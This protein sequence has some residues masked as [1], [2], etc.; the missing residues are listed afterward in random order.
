VRIPE[1]AYR[2]DSETAIC[3]GSRCGAPLVSTIACRVP[4]PV[5]GGGGVRKVPGR[6][7]MA[8]RIPVSAV[9]A[10]GRLR[11][12]EA[13]AVAVQGLQTTDFHNCGDGV[14]PHPRAAHAVVPGR[15]PR[16]HDHSGSF[17]RT[18][19]AAARSRHVR[20]RLDHA[21][22][23]APSH[24]SARPRPAH[25]P[26]GG[27]RKLH[28]SNPLRQARARRGWQGPGHWSRRSPR[29]GVRSRAFGG[30]PLSLTIGSRGIR[31]GPC[32]GR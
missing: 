5:L 23:A 10:P 19:P 11:A 28:W 26:G 27:G 24:A 15:L 1:R 22:S 2:I 6:V 21:P 13:V 7:S 30:H 8:R 3:V 25:R 20:D 14:A 31:P 16:Q 18:A 17:R 29:R 12:A 32:R 4:G 9:R